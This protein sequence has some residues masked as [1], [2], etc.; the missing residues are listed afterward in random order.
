MKL[1]FKGTWLQPRNHYWATLEL[2]LISPTG[3]AISLNTHEFRLLAI[4]AQNTRIVLSRDQIL[5]K[6]SGRNWIP[7][8]RSVDVSIGKLRKVIEEDSTQP[9]LI[10]TVHGNAYMLT[11][12]AHRSFQHMRDV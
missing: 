11:H 2:S 5:Q 9:R 12:L 7:D 1:S 6:S 3:E 10:R 4:L 8:D